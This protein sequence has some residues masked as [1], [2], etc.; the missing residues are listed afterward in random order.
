M[1]SGSDCHLLLITVYSLQDTYVT[2][3]VK[4]DLNHTRIEIHF[5]GE[6]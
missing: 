2:G 4:I 5:I 1:Y 6:Y 3:F